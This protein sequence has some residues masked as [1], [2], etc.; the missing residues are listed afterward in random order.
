MLTIICGSCDEPADKHG[1]PDGIVARYGSN[2]LDVVKCYRQP[3]DIQF[4]YW[5]VAVPTGVRERTYFDDP[6]YVEALNTWDLKY[7]T[8]DTKRYGSHYRHVEVS[9]YAVT[10]SGNVILPQNLRGTATVRDEQPRSNEGHYESYRFGVP[11]GDYDSNGT[12]VD[13]AEYVSPSREFDALDRWTDKALTPDNEWICTPTIQQLPP[14]L[15]R[16]TESL[17]EVAINAKGHVRPYANEETDSSD[18]NAYV[19]GAEGFLSVL[20]LDEVLTAKYHARILNVFADKKTHDVRVGSIRIRKNTDN[21]ITAYCVQNSCTGEATVDPNNVTRAQME[22]FVYQIVQHGNNHAAKF[23]R[24]R[25]DFYK[26]H[27]PNCDLDKC[28]PQVPYCEHTTTRNTQI[29]TDEDEVRFLLEHNSYC[30]D[31]RC[32]C[33]ERL[34]SLMP[35][36][37]V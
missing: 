11:Q 32:K 7:D 26:V 34:A 14:Y 21:T 23:I 5:Q 35:A 10:P 29:L 3:E 17:R 13:E 12:Y 16:S 6:E 24:E 18:R 30:K 4:A 9:D 22:S 36:L 33:A 2:D 25:D 8:A 15:P 1:S 28:D 27:A 31:S 20:M 37:A 19:E